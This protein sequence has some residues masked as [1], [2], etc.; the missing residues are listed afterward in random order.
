LEYFKIEFRNSIQRHKSRNIEIRIRRKGKFDIL[1]DIK[2]RLGSGNKF[3][4]KDFDFNEFPILERFKPFKNRKFG[5]QLNDSNS[6][7]RL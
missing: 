1:S 6:N 5:T 3:Q 7:Q 4:S 2:I